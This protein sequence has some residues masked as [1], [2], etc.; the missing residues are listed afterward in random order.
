MATA[1]DTKGTAW[2]TEQVNEKTG[3]TVDG[4]TVRVL[5]RKLAADGTIM[6]GDGRWTFTGVKDPAVLAVIKAVKAG[7]ADPK[8]R[9]RKPADETAE[10][11]A[12]K[13]RARKA[14]EPEVSEELEDDEELDLEEL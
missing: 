5:L 3:R 2:L 7:E 1:T 12:R 10:K 9:G 13:P 14:A 4:K 6:K 8:P 11:P